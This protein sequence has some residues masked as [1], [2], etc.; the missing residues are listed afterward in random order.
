MIKGC[1]KRMVIVSG[2]NDSSIEAAYFVMKDCAETEK[3]MDEDIVKKANA[4]I[5]ESFSDT[6]E[7]TVAKK[8][9]HRR[10]GE[11]KKLFASFISGILSGGALYF[12]VDKWI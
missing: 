2:L 3:M 9:K 6:E 4:I 1:R 12:I 10:K 8:N 11:T 7:F 5:E